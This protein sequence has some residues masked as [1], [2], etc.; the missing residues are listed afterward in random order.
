MR[1]L[2]GFLFFG[3]WFCLSAAEVIP[4]APTRHFNDYAHV[5]SQA[6][7]S[8]LD[9]TLEDFERETSNQI[10]VAVFPKMQ[11]DSSVEDYTV[12]VAQA[13]KVGV[14]GRNNGAVLF[15]FIQERK[16]F[17][18]VGYGLE[19]ALPDALAKQIIEEEIKPRFREANYDGGM[20]AGVS[21]I[22]A[23]TRGEYKGTGRTAGERP[24]QQRQDVPK[25]LVLGGFLGGFLLLG[26]LNRKRRVRRRGWFGYP[27]G[28]VIGGGDYP[29]T[30]GWTSGGGGG[31]FSSG[32]GFSG[33]GGS[34]GGGGAGG[35]W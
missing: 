5:V 25:F 27:G 7:V 10:L 17:L 30:G 15:V 14:K 31:G 3:W 11:S 16:M 1:L 32:G 13:W 23:A 33:G 12:R 29:S 6:T 18:Q 2:L 34:F 20:S 4:P 8:K 9:K 24:R 35:S 26:L 22:L 19:G 21:A 28:W